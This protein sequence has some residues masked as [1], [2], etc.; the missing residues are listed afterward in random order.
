MP[1]N[2]AD[3]RQLA[4]HLAPRLAERLYA[5]GQR[6]LDRPALAAR[7]G[8]SERGVTGLVGRGELPGGFLI[9]GVRRWDWAE[10]RHFLTAR[11]KR[12]PR[13]GRGLYDRTRA[14]GDRHPA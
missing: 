13:K 4:D 1:L 10:V 7:L 6:L 9:G 11:A 2:E 5:E 8:V 12:K 14:A 3:L